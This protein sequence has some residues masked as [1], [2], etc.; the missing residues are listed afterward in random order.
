M[1]STVRL[2]RDSRD[3]GRPEDGELRARRRCATR[4]R[5]SSRTA[6]RARPRSSARPARRRDDP[7][8]D[9]TVA[10][11]PRARPKP[12]GWSSPA[13]GPGIM[14]AG[15]EGAGAANSFGVSIRLPFEAAT[16]PVPRRRPEARQLPVL[17][18][19]QGHVR[20]GG[21]R[22]RA[23]ARRLRDAR[24]GVRAAHARADRQGAA[25][26]DRAPRRAGR[27][28]LAHVAAVR[29]QRAPRPRL[30]LAARPRA[31]ED[32]RRRRRRARGDHHASTATTTRC[33][34]STAISCCACT[35]CRR[36]RSSPRS[37]RSSPTSS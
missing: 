33:A 10:A 19:A 23:A 30:H 12:T 27:H 36:T 3:A 34:S 7:L 18:H 1:V 15:I 32:H 13:P 22:V 29:R 31:G 21:A 25:R 2:A 11:R 14:E 5:C 28:V 4:S 6:R 8:Y 20:E 17:L 37:T 9:Q 26:A 16:T 24:R 35:R